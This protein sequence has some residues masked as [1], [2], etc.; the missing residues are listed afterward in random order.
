MNGLALADT[1]ARLLDRHGLDPRRLILEITETAVVEESAAMLESLRA[2]DALGVRLTLDDFG[3]GFSSLRYLLALPLH[4]LK[5]DASFVAVLPDNQQAAEIIG[6][7][8]SMAHA[9]GK[10]VTAEGI[11]TEAQLRRVAELGCDEG[12]GYLLGRPQPLADLV[13]G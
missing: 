10:R 7:V 4:G 5:I 1:V 13:A 6:A 12:Q 11:E 2:L 8:A 3:K 9:L